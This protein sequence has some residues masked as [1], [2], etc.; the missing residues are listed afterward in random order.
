[1]NR[2]LEINEYR[3]QRYPPTEQGSLRAWN[4]ADEHL[5]DYFDPPVSLKGSLTICNDRFGFLTCHLNRFSP[6]VIINF[7]SQQ[8]AILQNLRANK[9]PAEGLRFIDPFKRSS[10]KTDMAIIK[11]PKSIDLFRL[12]L[13]EITKNLDEKGMVR[14]GF[15]TKYFTPQILSVAGKFFE[16]VE[17][18]R[19]WKKSR[20][21]TLKGLKPL[22]D[23]KIVNEIQFEDQTFKQYSGVFSA[24]HIDDSSQ[25]F[26]RYWKLK[27]LNAG[28]VLD[29]ASG[30]GF[31][32]KM[33]QRQKPDSE[34]HLLDDDWLAVESSRLNFSENDK[35]VFFHFNDSLENFENEMFDL[36]VCNPPFHFEHETNI[37][38][39]IRLFGEAKRCLAKEG[40]FQLV[41]N[42]HLN[43]KTHLRRLF[44][45]VEIVRKNNK[46]E[47]FDCRI[48]KA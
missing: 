32:A 41:A 45:S 17:Q 37:E 48:P 20:V 15:M 36:I 47:V 1:M 42:R 27:K 28:R 24:N 8:K 40:S 3:F 35:K 10:E 4:A 14:G 2:T 16:S 13:S 21:L 23:R 9:L 5:L 30:N 46:F 22:K 33:V 43:Y 31:L 39:A 7:A 34:I 44:K 12:Q 29:L 19:A 38:V 18:S 26:I 11:V 6:A 25:F